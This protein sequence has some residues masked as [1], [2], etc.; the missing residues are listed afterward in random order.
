MARPR[1]QAAQAQQE[2]EQQP[3]EPGSQ[4]IKV[5]ALARGYY[6]HL[7][8]PGDEFSVASAADLG[9]WMRPVQEPAEG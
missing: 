5:V 2:P 4:P 9:R 1:R 6:G 7:R 3:Q 8:E